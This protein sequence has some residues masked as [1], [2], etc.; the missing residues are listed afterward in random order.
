MGLC[1]P[2][3]KNKVKRHT[4]FHSVKAAASGLTGLVAIFPGN[5]QIVS[6]IV[7]QLSCVRNSNMFCCKILQQEL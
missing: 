2:L 7:R 3:G 1:F 6:V 4:F 5:R